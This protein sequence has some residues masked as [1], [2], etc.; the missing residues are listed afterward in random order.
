MFEGAIDPTII[1]P[2]FIR[3]LNTMKTIEVFHRC[4]VCGRRIGTFW[5]NCELEG[6]FMVDDVS[7]SELF[8]CISVNPNEVICNGCFTSRTCCPK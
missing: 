8:E 2:E 1:M 3:A 4:R 5:K 7:W 6:D